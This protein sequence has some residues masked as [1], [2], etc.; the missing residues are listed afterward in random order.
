MT[1]G[2]RAVRWILL[3]SIP[4]F[5]LTLTLLL[6]G[7]KG[8]WVAAILAIPLGVYAVLIPSLLSLAPAAD[9]PR[10]PVPPRRKLLAVVLVVLLGGILPGTIWWGFETYGDLD[11][12]LGG[13]FVLEQGEPVTIPAKVEKAW[14]GNLVFIPR[15]AN[16]QQ[17]NSCVQLRDSLR[18]TPVADGKPLDAAIA[19]DGERVSVPIAKGTRDVKL[20]VLF[21]DP[22]NQGCVVNATLSGGRL[23]R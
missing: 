2:R 20:I 21:V 16:T 14:G 7:E 17:V 9:P 4:T 12:D 10:P 8:A 11:V 23:E 15:L 18:V 5:L 22:S 3:A 6:L 19:E 1:Q 13:S